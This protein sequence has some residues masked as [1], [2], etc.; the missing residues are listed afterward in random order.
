MAESLQ[1]ISALPTGDIQSIL[2]GELENDSQHSLSQVPN[3]T[4]DATGL[5]SVRQNLSSSFNS[6]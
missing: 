5:S 3:E 4:I 1:G 6:L 2:E